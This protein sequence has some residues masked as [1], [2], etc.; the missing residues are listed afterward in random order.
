LRIAEIVG[1][2]ISIKGRDKKLPREEYPPEVGRVSWGP[3]G[4]L[5]YGAEKQERGN[6]LQRRKIRSKTWRK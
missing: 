5:R 4:E 3:D 1:P 6:S 2:F